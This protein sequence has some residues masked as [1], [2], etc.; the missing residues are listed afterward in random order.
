MTRYSELTKEEQH[1]LLVYIE[2]HLDLDSIYQV[3]SDIMND[4]I[5]SKCFKSKCECDEDLK[6]E[7]I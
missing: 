7:T 3:K 5:C 4:R 2:R 1:E 6:Q